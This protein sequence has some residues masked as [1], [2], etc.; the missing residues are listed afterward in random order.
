MEQEPPFLFFVSLFLIKKDKAKDDK[1][2]NEIQFN[3]EPLI[4]EKR[5]KK[6]SRILGVEEDD[7][8]L[9]VVSSS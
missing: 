6:N 3:Q 9:F 5:R 1:P 2:R 8:R 4:Q 7:L